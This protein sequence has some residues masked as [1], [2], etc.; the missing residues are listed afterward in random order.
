MI[1]IFLKDDVKKFKHEFGHMI[2][3]NNIHFGRYS[4]LSSLY[5]FNCKKI[6]SVYER[7]ILKNFNKPK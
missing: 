1:E 6:L 5:I 4:L 2:K 7:K 3:M